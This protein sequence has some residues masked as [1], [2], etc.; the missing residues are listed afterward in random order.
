MRAHMPKKY[1]RNLPEAPLIG[2]LI[3]TAQARSQQ[4]VE[5]APTVSRRRSVA[6]AVSGCLPPGLL[7]EPKIE[8]LTQL[9]VEGRACQRCPLHECATQAVPG[10]GPA[11][12][13]LMLVGEQP[14]DEEDIA[15]RPFVGPAGRLL[16]IALQRTGIE[17]S[18]CFVTNAVKHFKFEA[19]G[20][21]RLHKTPNQAEIER[22]RWWLRA[23]RDLL[24]PEVIIALGASAGRSILGEAIRVGEL[25]G[26]PM[27][28]S[29][30]ETLLVTVHPSYLLRLQGE[31][32]K[33]REWHAF[34]A[35]L[36][37]ARSLQNAA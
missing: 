10:E 22:C 18:A 5:A 24:K 3:A 8:S 29:D 19:R 7:G 27:P 15:G 20:K 36:R 35:D 2:S 34:L 16:D 4:M 1:W 31:D 25:R 13:R 21:R 12:A 33:R 37:L 6:K 32:V 28:L 30:T 23:E 26:R 14:G 11:N 17:R 9:A